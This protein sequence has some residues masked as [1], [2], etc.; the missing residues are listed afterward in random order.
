M[1]RQQDSSGIQKKSKSRGNRPLQ[2]F[3]RRCRAKGLDD[4]GI[5]KLLLDR[6]S[7]L[8]SNVNVVVE[9]EHDVKDEGMDKTVMDTFD[10]DDKNDTETMPPSMNQVR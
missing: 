3:R 9:N 7:S 1:F 8:T 6:P 2:R 5:R 4:D 10:H